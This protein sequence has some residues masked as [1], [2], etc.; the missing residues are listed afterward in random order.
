MNKKIIKVLLVD[1]SPI[2]LVILKRILNAA[3]DI[4]VVGTAAD[5]AE[6]LQLVEKLQPDVIC[7][8]LHMPKLDGLELTKTVM[9]NFPRPILVTSVSVQE[10]DTHNVFKLLEAG[11]VDVFPKPRGGLLSD[12]QK[13]TQ[14]FIA[15]VR[16]LA[17]VVVFHKR[18]ED[19][20]LVLK[21]KSIV[22]I[23]IIKRQL[24]IIAIGASTGGPQA[25]QTI[26]T[27]LPANFPLPI[28]C[29]QHIGEGFLQ[30]LVDWLNPQCP[31]MVKL[32]VAGHYPAPGTI[33]FPKEG[34]HLEFDDYGRFV[35]STAPS[36]KGH[37]P[38]ITI[39]FNAIA[40]YFGQ[41]ALGILLTGMGSD[42]AEGL[43]SILQAG[44][45]TITQDEKSS[46]V[47]GMPKEAI[48][49]GASQKTLSLNEMA[50][51]IMK[52]IHKP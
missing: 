20:P 25:L 51:A 31:M 3:S 2:V 4:K 44:G 6:A 35:E 48:K 5:G 47:F 26:L 1:D 42:G 46:V 40:Q 30:G 52:Y 32:A 29:V 45:V 18:R 43:L 37:R 36:L 21:T 50:P 49:L 15:K 11:A 33:Y 8:D 9:E 22:P 7:T 38:S 39:T 19:Q 41:E 24:K 12:Y 14:D 28:I 34:T 16:V 10:E 13:I 23:S 17:G 27:Q